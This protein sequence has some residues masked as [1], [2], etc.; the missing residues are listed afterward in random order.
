MAEDL[1]PASMNHV[2]DADPATKEIEPKENGS[3]YP[4]IDEAWIAREKKLVRKLDATL[5]PM[6]WV[7]YLFNYLDRNNIAYAI[8]LS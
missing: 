7:L 6:V 3:A 2:E 1:K 8:L 4:P 5:M